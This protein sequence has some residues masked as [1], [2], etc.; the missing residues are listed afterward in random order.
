MTATAEDFASLV[1]APAELRNPEKPGELGDLPV[2]ILVHGIPF[3]GPATA[4]EADWAAGMERNA[5]LSSNSRLIIAP[6]SNHMI[7]LDE[8]ALVV[9][10]V[11][12]VHEAARANGRIG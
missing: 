11:R 7:H 5:T 1:R 3:P 2:I 4:M 9:D 6:K 12:R 10:A 8:P